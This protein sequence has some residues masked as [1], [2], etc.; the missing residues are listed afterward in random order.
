MSARRTSTSQNISK[1]NEWTCQEHGRMQKQ[2]RVESVDSYDREGHRG[3]EMH[4]KVMYWTRQEHSLIAK[5][6]ISYGD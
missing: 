1:N 6:V 2:L 5:I 3:P 4:V